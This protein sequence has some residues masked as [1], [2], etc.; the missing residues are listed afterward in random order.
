MHHFIEHSQQLY[1]LGNHDAIFIR[2]KE[3]KQS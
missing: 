2:T 3:I 1:E